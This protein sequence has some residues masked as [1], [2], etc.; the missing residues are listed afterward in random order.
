MDKAEFKNRY[1]AQMTRIMGQYEAYFE[2][3]ATSAYDCYLEDPEDVTP[4]DQ[5]DIEVEE[6]GHNL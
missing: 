2:F 6:W 1:I 4:E 3:A 5:A